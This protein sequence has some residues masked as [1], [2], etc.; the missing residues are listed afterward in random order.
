MAD[1]T[2]L[3]R[4]SFNVKEMKSVKSC[5]SQPGLC[6]TG[7]MVRDCPAVPLESDTWAEA[8][9]D[10]QRGKRSLI[11]KGDRLTPCLLGGEA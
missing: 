7:R 11:L 9:R 1:L 6:K 3:L 2:S 4:T 8:L 10:Q 5:F